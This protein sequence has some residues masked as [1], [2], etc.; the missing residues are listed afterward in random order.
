MAAKPPAR[1]V[2][3]QSTPHSSEPPDSTRML[4]HISGSGRTSSP[5]GCCAVSGCEGRASHQPKAQT[6]RTGKQ[7]PGVVVATRETVDW[8][9]AIV[10]LS[11]LGRGR[12]AS[13]GLVNSE[14]RCPAL[15]LP[16]PPI[17]RSPEGRGQDPVRTWMMRSVFLRA[18]VALKSNP[19]T[20][21]SARRWGELVSEARDRPTPSRSVWAGSSPWPGS[22]WQSSA[23]GLSVSFGLAA[24]VL[25][26]LAGCQRELPPAAAIDAE[27]FSAEAAWA[28][29]S[30][31]VFQPSR[32]PEPDR[33][34]GW[35]MR[36][37]RLTWSEGVAEVETER[38]THRFV[39]PRGSEGARYERV[40]ADGSRSSDSTRSESRRG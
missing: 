33:A 24:G 16:D 13:P 15:E 12:R 37:I 21:G 7:S 8:G 31:L 1:S 6:S 17:P 4:S 36:P 11:T 18:M 22:P 29:R 34:T 38:V 9:R 35:D 39:D 2:I 23:V 28:C 14:L 5:E 3:W 26:S 19:R 10:S 25:L 30:G 20:K 27:E 32:G 40:A